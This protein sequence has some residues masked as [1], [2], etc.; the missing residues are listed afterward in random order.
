[1]IRTGT[2]DRTSCFGL[3]NFWECLEGVQNVP[4][5]EFLASGNWGVRRGVFVWRAGAAT[6]ECLWWWLLCFLMQ[7]FFFC[8][9]D[10]KTRVLGSDD[11]PPTQCASGRV[12]PSL[13]VTFLLVAVT[14]WLFFLLLS[15]FFFFYDNA[16]FHVCPHVCDLSDSLLSQTWLLVFSLFIQG[17]VDK[18]KNVRVC[19]CRRVFFFSCNR[20]NMYMFGKST[21]PRSASSTSKTVGGDDPRSCYY[22]LFSFFFLARS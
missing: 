6:M 20:T 4:W 1:M 8:F 11:T 7:R 13:R 19:V 17:L 22:F 21:R 16:V 18:Q 14:C 9:G 10:T 3:A 2:R 5:W 15:C 12:S